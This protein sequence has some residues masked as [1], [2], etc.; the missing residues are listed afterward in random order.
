M[1]KAFASLDE[2]QAE[3]VMYGILGKRYTPQLLGWRENWRV[4]EQPGQGAAQRREVLHVLQYKMGVFADLRHLL[5]CGGAEG[6]WDWQ[7]LGWAAGGSGAVG[8]GRR[9]TGSRS[10][11]AVTAPGWRSQASG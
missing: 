3:V 1:I 4:V 6:R 5:K 11:L 2:A 7:P 8:C 10:A 9:S